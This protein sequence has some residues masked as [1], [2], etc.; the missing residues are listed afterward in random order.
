MNAVTEA[1]TFTCPSKGV[2]ELGVEG[3]TYLATAVFRGTALCK[4]MSV[5]PDPELFGDS[6]IGFQDKGTTAVV[7]KTESSENQ[8]TATGE[9]S[10]AKQQKDAI[11]EESSPSKKQQR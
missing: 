5:I 10:P 11:G 3:Q 7:C 9:S 6:L 2:V 8:K 1:L 4:F